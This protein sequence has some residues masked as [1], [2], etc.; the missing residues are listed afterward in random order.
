MP[1]SNTTTDKP[2]IPEPEWNSSAL[3]MHIWFDDLTRWL[4]HQDKGYRSL[5]ERGY[6]INR[7]RT[8]I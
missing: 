5:I 3:T 4:P 6:F 8:I 2:T 7:D 1:S